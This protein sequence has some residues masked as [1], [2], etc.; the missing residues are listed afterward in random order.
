MQKQNIL[1]I[2]NPVAGRKKANKTLY[3][4][5][6]SLCRNNCKTTIF[7]SGKLKRNLDLF[8]IM[9]MTWLRLVMVS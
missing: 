2:V 8:R 4:I 6:D 1:L 5:V 7:L 3:Q 9:P